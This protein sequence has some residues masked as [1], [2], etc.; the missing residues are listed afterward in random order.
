MLTIPGY[1]LRG[2]LKATGTNLLFH[3][4]R[5]ADG[6]PL[7]L[8]TP[9]A[10]VGPRESERY[11]REFDILQR[12][13]DVRGVLRAHG[14]EQLPDRPSLLLEAVE[15]EVLSEF[16]DKPF[17]VLKTLDVAISLTSTLAEIHRRGVI[18][19]DIKPSNIILTPSGEARLIDF[20]TA[21]LQRIEHVDA[22]PTT[23]IEGT[24]AYM[25]PEQ[26]GR[27]N[28]TVDY[29]TDFYSLGITLYE[30]LT[31]GRPFHGRDALEWFHVHMAV[32]PPPLTERVPDLPPV[33]SSIVLK[34]LAKVAEERYQSADGLKADLERCRDNLLRSVHED[35]PLGVHDFPTHFQLPQRLYGRD[36]H[37][38][39]LLQGFERVALSGRPE[40]IL[41]RGYSGSGKS[42]V[43]HELHKPVVRHR[44][45]FLSGKFDQFQQASPYATLAQ[46]IRGL[47]QQ[48]LA[49]S[50]ESLAQWRERL[51]DTWKGQGQL[52]VDVVPQLELIAGKQPPVP[53]LPPSE[54]AH[55]FN[56]VFREFLGLFATSEHPL[57]LFLDDLQWAD[58]AS[59]QLLQDLL[60]HEETPP[61][62]L[63]GTYRDNEVNPSHPLVRTL[64]GMR[65]AGARMRELQ[66]EPLGL[67]DVRQL[68]ADALSG[69]EEDLIAPL[70]ALAREKTGGNPFFLLHFMLTLHQD[71]LLVRAP[72]GTWR[73]DEAGV[74]AR[75][76]SDNVVDFLVGKL[77][78]LSSGTQNLLRLAACVGN[79]FSLQLLHFLS[80]SPEAAHLEKD[81]EPAFQENLLVRIGPDQGRFIHDRIHQAAY[82][83]IDEQER[84]RVHLRIGRLMLAHLPPESLQEQLFDVVSQLNAGAE[85]LVDDAERLRVARLNAEAGRRAKAS[86]ALRSAITYFARAFQLLPG[87][88]WET[89]PALA[90]KLR[91]EHAICEFMTGNA[92]GALRQVDEFMDRALT[93]GD[94]AAVYCLKTDILIGMGDIQTAGTC[95]LEGLALLGM[96]MSPN[97]SWE[98]V[99]AANEEVRQLLGERSIESLVDLPLMTDPDM[100]AVMSLLGALYAPSFSTS[101]NLL[102]LH[103]SRM[104]ALSLR[105]GNT[106]ASVHG[107]S[108]YGLVL[109]AVFGRYQEGLAF[110]QLACA[111]V[112]HRGFTPLRGKALY[113]LEI[114][115]YWTQ[116]LSTALQLVRE[117]FQQSL[118]NSDSQVAGYCCNHIVTDRFLLGH[119]LEEVYRESVANLHFTRGAEFLDPRDIIHFTQRHV[120]QLRG[121]TSSFS[122]MSGDDFDEETF[123]AGLTPQRMRT[124]RCWYWLTKAQSRY[125]SGAYQEALEYTDKS[126]ELSWS[127]L[128]HIQLLDLHLF[129]ALSLAACAAKM[130][131]EERERALMEI[132]QHQR[133]LA[134]WARHCPSTFL[135]AERLVAAERARLMGQRD[136]ALQ[137]YEQSIQSARE[138]GFIQ[139]AALAYEL[140]AR[141]W[142]ERQVPTIAEAYARKAREAYLRWGAKG[143]V[144]HLDS[145]WPFLTLPEGGAQN[146]QDTSS[147]EIDA[148]TL[149][150]AQQAIS[151]EIVLERLAATLLRIAMENAGAQRGALLLPRGDTLTVSALSGTVSSEAAV[152]TAEP[153]LPW[154]VISYVKRAR[155]HVLIG[156]ASLPHP[157]SSD[158]WLEHSHAR[159]VLCLPLLRQE[160]FRGVLYL[161]NTLA[162]NAFSPARIALLGHLASQ[163]AISIEN[164]RLYADVQK[165]EAALRRAND[166]LEKRVEERTRELKLTQVR[167]VDAARAAGMA[168]IAANVLH[169]VGNVLTSAVINLQTVRETMSASR[170][171]RLK[172]ATQMI[173]EHHDHL[174]DFLTRD[175]RGAQL[176]GY[177]SALASELLREQASLQEGMTA[178]DMHLEHIRAIVQVQQTYAHRTLVTEECDL[179]Q[180]V[181]DALRLQRASLQRHGVTVTQEL[182]S[183]PRISLDKHRVLQI[184]INLISNAKQA[185]HQLPESQRHL[186]V[187]LDTEDNCARIQIVDNGMGIVPEIRGRLFGQGFTTRAG[188]HGLGLHSSA[189]EAKLLGGSISLESEG[190]GKGAT[191]ILKLPLS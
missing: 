51:L 170:V 78:Q 83:L 119:D 73:W 53:E 32:A 12:I 82:A 64:E 147:T 20:G 146:T 187:R 144:Q 165:A 182:T 108:W 30:L 132:S 189:L 42:A 21:T 85:W 19:K 89:E 76:Y 105:H 177:L 110:G 183:V 81:L 77:R 23:L 113:G 185:M 87:D 127:S 160:E 24:L 70:S 75:G 101:T 45:F 7:I 27:M 94:T 41:V 162:T 1:T 49:G 167:L 141:F 55:R 155:E 174:A 100:E 109:G 175:Q 181:E 69:A 36:T 156:D 126:A 74:Q 18:H 145:E 88:P 151:E 157:F 133:Q 22:A 158:A 37:A 56:R 39:A 140:A 125:M 184:L 95:L 92:T 137:A 9:V 33:L 25:S 190:P 176:P 13:R 68:V 154:S 106:S 29:R 16:T 164:A 142:R 134:E 5:D 43:V 129:R 80:D 117:A 67:E 136:E 38:A 128:G 46:A 98:E 65:A 148:L 96:P 35:F 116:P 52:L 58:P 57:V 180:L 135:T 143:K 112:E 11:R 114:I 139:R 60:T 131:P 161:E 123:E 47:T 153:Q 107:Y 15:G 118:Q 102:V 178:M 63:L 50:D 4:L 6:Q 99:E 91:L 172:Q 17:E 191:A 93:R 186:Y 115:S 8:K 121:L 163:A 111:L 66:L 31:G 166:E 54:A 48:L 90:F 61:L 173:D 62:L 97:P 71:G 159:S 26:T 3:A 79:T 188:G 149:V 103:L 169:N 28:R 124:M 14:C 104:T 59:L 138:H 10:S 122:T 130:P 86:I 150:K 171:G 44:S 84:K 168:E 34:L 40:L 72:D 152:S 2:A 120:Q 179:S